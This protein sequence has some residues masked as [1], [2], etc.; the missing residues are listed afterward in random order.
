MKDGAKMISEAFNKRVYLMVD[1]EFGVLKYG[2]FNYYPI[3]EKMQFLKEC[4]PCLKPDP[5]LVKIQIDEKGR[6]FFYW[7]ELT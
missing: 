6:E 1:A 5:K 4:P 2:L 7:E 3:T